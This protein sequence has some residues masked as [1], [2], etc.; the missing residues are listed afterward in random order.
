MGLETSLLLLVSFLLPAALL[1]L[2]MPPFIRYLRRAGR[3]A[4]DAHKTDA[5]QVAEPA[6]PALFVCLAAGEAAVAVMYGSLVPLVLVGVMAIAFIIGLYDDLLVLGGKAKPALLV[7]AGV[8]LIVAEYSR[9]QAV[10]PRLFFP[11]LGPTSPHP[12]LY[13]IFVLAAIP[14]VS[15]AYN[16][17]DSF[18]GEISGFTTVTAIALTFAILL[19]LLFTPG[20]P[21]D[22]LA[23]SLPLLAIG[24]GF[25]F[26][27]R[28]PSRAFDGDSGSLV[29]GALFAGVAITAG[30]EIAA[31][32]A[33]IPAVL[34]SYYIITSARGFVE[35]R[36]MGRP[37]YLGEDGKMHAGEGPGAPVTLIRLLLLDGPLSEQE[38][39]RS[40]LVL[41][42]ASCLLS[43]ITSMATWWL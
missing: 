33:I 32:V 40:I 36:R 29:L 28:Y 20:Y 34:N 6:G 27:N 17:M 1:F 23:S 19:K 15:N 5:P 16:M 10:D 3:V 18:N 38:L 8:P 2:V 35:R 25:Y 13:A 14:V 41:T 4:K 31:V 22:R 37:T 30:V 12:T 43:A 21:V 7:L 9:I 26:F 42:A 11:F 39:V 24:I